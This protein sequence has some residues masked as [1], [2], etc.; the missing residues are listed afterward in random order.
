[1]TGGIFLPSI[2]VRR[3]GT[4]MRITGRVCAS[5]FSVKRA[6]MIDDLLPYRRNDAMK[7]NDFYKTRLASNMANEP[8]YP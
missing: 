8:L 6:S 5:V 4:M 7:K 1:M 3:S 2:V